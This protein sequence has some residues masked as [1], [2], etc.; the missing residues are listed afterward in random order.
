[1]CRPEAGSSAAVSGRAIQS[2]KPLFVRQPPF[3]GSA[4]SRSLAPAGAGAGSNASGRNR[5][6]NLGIKSSLWPFS[7]PE[8]DAS[9]LLV[10]SGLAGC[11]GLPSGHPFLQ[12]LAPFCTSFPAIV[13]SLCPSPGRYDS[14]G[15]GRWEAPRSGLAY[16]TLPPREDHS[17]IISENALIHC[18]S[19]AMVMGGTPSRCVHPPRRAAG[20]APPSDP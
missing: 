12:I 10:T 5:T 14:G 9:Y 15:R 7:R 1:M 8:P 3:G 2:N 6:Y 11:S 13:P 17:C 19:R 18:E 16:L 4:P 20:G